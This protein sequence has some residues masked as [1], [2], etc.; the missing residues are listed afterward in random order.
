MQRGKDS[1]FTANARWTKGGT[2]GIEHPHRVDAQLV[3]S[4][5]EP[6]AR[7]HGAPLRRLF[8]ELH[9]YGAVERGSIYATLWPDEVDT[10]DEIEQRIGVPAPIDCT[11]V[12][13]RHNGLYQGLLPSGGVDSNPVV[14]QLYWETNAG[15]SPHLVLTN[16]DTLRA[17]AT[18][19]GGAEAH[20]R[21]VA[22]LRRR[23]PAKHY[24][25][26]VP[27]K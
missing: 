8:L 2:I 20:G 23:E 14:A 19:T 17:E 26:D 10:G 21:L 24:V 22:L 13:V 16:G 11:H 15:A 18:L 9:F 27:L 4:P 1:L 6:E 12:F 7:T 25:A 3:L 5:L